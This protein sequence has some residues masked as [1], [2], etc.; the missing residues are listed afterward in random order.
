MTPEIAEK[1]KKHIQHQVNVCKNVIVLD[2]DTAKET[3]Y[4][5]LASHNIDKDCLIV[6]DY[7]EASDLGIINSESIQLVNEFSHIK[8]HIEIKYFEGITSS[9]KNKVKSS[10]VELPNKS[11]HRMQNKFYNR[12]F[13]K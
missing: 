5:F 11:K 6:I 4:N 2:V 9:E 3:F 13:G 1:I 8:H 7:N 10:I 12:K